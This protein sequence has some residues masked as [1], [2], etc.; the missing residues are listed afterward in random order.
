MLTKLILTL[1]AAAP[2]LVE[3]VAQEANAFTQAPNGVDKAK[4][5]LESLGHLST[6]VAGAVAAVK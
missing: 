4:T 6:A 1:L 3:D 5:V 2:H